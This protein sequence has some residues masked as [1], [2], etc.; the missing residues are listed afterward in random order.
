MCNVSAQPRGC[1][2]QTDCEK[3]MVS[4]I[5]TFKTLNS[6][7]GQHG[8]ELFSYFQNSKVGNFLLAPRH[9]IIRP[10]CTDLQFLRVQKHILPSAMESDLPGS[11]ENPTRTNNNSSGDTDTKVCHLIF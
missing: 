9:Q 3:Q 6:V 7:Y 2:E 10:E 8:V 11:S 5:E 1:T 4:I